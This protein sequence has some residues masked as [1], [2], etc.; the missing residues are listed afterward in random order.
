MKLSVL[1]S[2]SSL[3]L[4]N[5]CTGIRA[6]DQD[7]ELKARWVVLGE[8]GQ[9]IARAITSAAACPALVQDGVALP[10]TVRAA[11]ATEAQRKTASKSEIS[12]PS[13]FP[14]LTCEAV[15]AAGTKQARIGSQVLPLPPAAIE[16]IVVIGDSGCRLKA[17]DNYYQPCNDGEKWAFRSMIAKAAQFKP[18]LVVHVGDYHYRENPCPDDHPECAGSP[19]GYGWDTWNADFFDPAAALLK[20]APWVMVRG[21]HESCARA[22]QGWWRLLDP[23]PLQAGRDCNLESNDLRG[24]Y[25]APYAVPL[26]RIG[27][28]LAQII[29]FDSAKVP[30]KALALDD[31]AYPIYREQIQTVDRLA[32]TADFNLFIEH[33]PVLGLAVEKK[34]SG[35]LDV[36]PGNAALQALLQ[37]VHPQRLFAANIHATIAGHVHLFEALT[38]ATDHP[39]Q[40]VSGNGGSSLDTPVPQPLAADVTPFAGAKV[41]HFSNSN[42][43]GFM[44]M[45]RYVDHWQV[46]A[47]NLQGKVLRTCRMTSKQT[48]CDATTP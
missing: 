12:K 34:R 13:A 44:T 46:R 20:T 37:E 19:W 17:A 24:D 26:G 1:M 6:P 43:V 7:A 4:L 15:I 39:T 38:F 30:N 23:R 11:A 18:D 28:E 9:A 2:V 10:M 3:L 5:A 48:D 32:G 47:W 16:K 29:V 45:E 35:G 22:G 8:N 21:N 27:G 25:S 14:V 33:H 36:K 31:P 41:A 40:F 42:E